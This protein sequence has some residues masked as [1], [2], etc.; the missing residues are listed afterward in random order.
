VTAPVAR[1]V[2]EHGT[3][4]TRSSG[5][6]DRLADAPWRELGPA[7]ARRLAELIGPVLGAAFESGLLPSQSTLSIL[8]VPVPA[9]R[10]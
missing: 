3:A 2:E 1:G 7:R 5:R 8:T 9:P 6:T 4:G 10:P